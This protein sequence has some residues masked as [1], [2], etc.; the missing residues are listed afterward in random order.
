[1]CRW[2]NPKILGILLILFLFKGTNLIFSQNWS[3]FGGSSSRDGFSKMSGPK[4]FNKTS[5]E[6]QSTGSTTLGNAVY[7][8]GDRFVQSR[9]NFSPYRGFVECRSLINGQLI[10][11][12]PTIQFNSILYC[13]GFN[14]DAVYV[15]DYSD[16]SIY[17]L[18]PDNGSVHWKSEINSTTFGAYPGVVYTCDGD[19]ILAGKSEESKFTVRLDKSNGKV[20]WSNNTIIAITPNFALAANQDRVY[21]LTGGITTPIVLTAIDINTGQNLF[22]SASLMGDPDQENPLVLGPEGRIYFWRDG[23]G[24]FAMRDM[25]NSFALDWVYLPS[26]FT[27]ASLTG[28]IAVGPDHDIFTFEQDRMIK[29]DHV[30]G[31]KIAITESLSLSQ[32][33]VT[34]SSDS[35][36]YLNDG[37]GNFYIYSYDLQKQYSRLSASGNV[38]CNPS[39]SYGGHMIITQAGN[40]I[41]AYRETTQRKPVSDFYSNQRII[42]VGDAIDFF[43]QSSYDPEVWEWEFSGGEPG[44]SDLKNPVGIIYYKPGVYKVSLKTR[45]FYGEDLNTRDCFIEV[46]Q[47]TNVKTSVLQST[48]IVNPNPCR[49]LIWISNL[50]EQ[51]EITYTISDLSGK[52]VKKGIIQPNNRI[53]SLAEFQPGLYLL[54]MKGYQPIKISLIS[55]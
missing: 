42:T 32:P 5:W 9:I 18:N 51:S 23:N 40:K 54:W 12:S 6:V 16:G 33:S 45:N 44:T 13:I 10:W 41:S 15:N 22:H 47:A 29:I 35:L 48:P 3:T 4:Q 46:N 50:N 20:R 14:E 7:S 24:L 17:S 1:M 34:I 37:K 30:S 11:K 19:I 36:V 2:I 53:V 55:N 49:D 43:D 26:I 27:G 52:M 39:L 31:Q 28:N 21:R 25:G 38:Y 8:F